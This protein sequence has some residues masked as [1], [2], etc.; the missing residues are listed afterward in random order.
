VH[1]LSD[2]DVEAALA[3]P[4]DGQPHLPAGKRRVRP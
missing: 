3:E 4:L 1:A 2:R